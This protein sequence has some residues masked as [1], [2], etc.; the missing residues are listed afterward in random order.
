MTTLQKG[1]GYL[2]KLNRI[3]PYGPAIPPLNIAPKIMRSYAQQTVY[4]RMFIASFFPKKP[5]TENKR[6]VHP[7]KMDK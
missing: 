3:L 5:K 1:L 2:L 7:R 4:I 6:D